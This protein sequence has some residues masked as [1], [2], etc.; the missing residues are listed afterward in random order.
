MERF[1]DFF[2]QPDFA[3][4]FI[5]I[6]SVLV[7]EVSNY[8]FAYPNNILVACGL[9]FLGSIVFACFFSEYIGVVLMACM[10]MTVALVMENIFIYCFA[11]II[12]MSCVGGFTALYFSRVGY[13]KHIYMRKEINFIKIFIFAN[14]IPTVVVAFLFLRNKD[15][16]FWPLMIIFGFGFIMP[17]I[18]WQKI[19]LDQK[20][21]LF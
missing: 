2:K 7:F 12:V 14:I 8:F 16:M 20:K 15:D 4:L 6:F 13:I 9:M 21:F 1:R 3:S 11:A 5:L 19:S 18:L 10:L 17:F